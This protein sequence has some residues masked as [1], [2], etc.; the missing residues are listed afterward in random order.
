M[1]WSSTKCQSKATRR[2][3]PLLRDRLGPNPLRKGKSRRRGKWR[4]R[5]GQSGRQRN[6]EEQRKPSRP[7]RKRAP[8][9]VAGASA[10]VPVSRK[11]K[12]LGDFSPSLFL[13]LCHL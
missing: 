9:N 8:R 3:R 11:K 2:P 12:R 5:S 13:F 7:G 6:Q 10:H 1:I 4:R